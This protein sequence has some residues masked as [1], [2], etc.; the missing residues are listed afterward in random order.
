MQKFTGTLLMVAHD[1]WLLSQVGAE[2]WELNENGITVHA[3]FAVYD[4]D[5]RARLAG[6]GTDSR[7]GAA[8]SA[9]GLPK[10]SSEA[11]REVAPGFS[12]E[13]Q[14]R[15]KRE[16]A[17]KRNALHKEL[18]PLQ[19]KYTALEEELARV[20]DEQSAVEGRLADPEVYADHSRSGELLKRFEDCKR[21]GEDLLEEMAG[22]EEKITAIKKQAESE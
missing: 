2:A 13:E 10:M 3:G 15:L 6:A 21:R 16:Q 22:L 18:K 19:S 9:A 17:E 14:K 12:R 8:L 1:R 11:A 4:A 5:R 20:L 7:G